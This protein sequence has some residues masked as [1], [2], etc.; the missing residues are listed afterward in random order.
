MNDPM[1]VLCR[2]GSSPY[3]KVNQMAFKVLLTSAVCDPKSIPLPWPEDVTY[4]MKTV[5][6]KLLLFLFYAICQI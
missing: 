6:L 4:K 5:G 1:S 2:G 3:V